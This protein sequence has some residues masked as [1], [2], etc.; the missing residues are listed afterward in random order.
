MYLKLLV[1]TDSGI[2]L[3]PGPCLHP[4]PP[5][6]VEFLSS[7]G[8]SAEESALSLGDPREK[9][10][11]ERKSPSGQCVNSHLL[12]PAESPLYPMHS[13]RQYW[14]AWEV[15][16]GEG[17]CPHTHA[18]S[19]WHFMMQ[20]EKT[21]WESQ[22]FCS[23]WVSKTFEVKHPSLIC[24]RSGQSLAQAMGQL[25]LLFSPGSKVLS[26]QRIMS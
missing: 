20:Y 22:T 10:T 11:K 24:T 2:H 15:C 21:E 5:N 25:V 1:I 18:S 4:L 7:L 19:T 13:P 14:A 12:S 16:G 3:A 17:W 23:V 6:T 26:P 8:S 9:M